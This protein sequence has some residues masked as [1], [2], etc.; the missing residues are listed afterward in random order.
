MRF[1]IGRVLQAAL[2]AAILET[3]ADVVRSHS[4]HPIPVGMYAIIE[5]VFFFIVVCIAAFISTRISSAAIWAQ[6]IV[7]FVI[8]LAP[9]ALS[10]LTFYRGVSYYQ[11]GGSLLVN[12]HQITTAGVESFALSICLSAVIALIATAVY[13]R[14]GSQPIHA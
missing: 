5:F 6:R 9:S 3:S 11:K 8:V 1:L 2:V 13:F 10:Y 7:F 4:F 12:D 14:A